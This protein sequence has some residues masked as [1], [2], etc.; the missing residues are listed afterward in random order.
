MQ[1]S[2]MLRLLFYTGVRVAELCSIQV[3]DINHVNALLRRRRFRCPTLAGGLGDLV[4]QAGRLCCS[5]LWCW[6]R[7][8]SGAHGFLLRGAATWNWA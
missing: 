8:K 7:Q 1:H 6:L 4:E 3:G 2:L 5:D